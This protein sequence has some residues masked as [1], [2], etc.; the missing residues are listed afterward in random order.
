VPQNPPYTIEAQFTNIDLKKLT[1][2]TPLKEKNI[3]G[4]LEGKITL[5]GYGKNLETLRGNGYLKLSGGQLWEVPLLK[6]LAEI[7]NL[8]GLEKIVFREVASSFSVA[9]KYI[10]T[11]DLKC[12]SN[13]L[14]LAAEGALG[15][16]GS[17]DF[18]VTTT[19]SQGLA[20]KSQL[21][22]IAT[23]IA[24]ET[25]NFLGEFKLR[26]TVS[27]PKWAFLPIPLD[28]ILKQ[29]VKGLLEGIFE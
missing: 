28:K 4:L 15:F 12:Y 16:D 19:F 7:L 29:K 23:I 20:R 25:G 18:T 22:K 5:G 10:V 9:N 13:D 14:T 24:D 11:K 3:S 17:L 26:G 2:D 6:G 1:A 27:E 8:T 21:G